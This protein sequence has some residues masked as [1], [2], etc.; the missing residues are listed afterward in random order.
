MD[1]LRNDRDKSERSMKK[2]FR[3]DENKLKKL[4]REVKDKTERP[5]AG[6]QGPRRRLDPP[7]RVLVSMG[8]DDRA[9]AGVHRRPGLS[10]A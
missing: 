9:D 5:G 7:G 10:R 4:K 2:E 6:R 3:D 1:T 8:E